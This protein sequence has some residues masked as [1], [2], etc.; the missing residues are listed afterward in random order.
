MVI[1]SFMC[2]GPAKAYKG[3]KSNFIGCSYW[4]YLFFV[5]LATPF[6]KSTVI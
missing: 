5:N 3:P 1:E 4:C 6:S 2:V